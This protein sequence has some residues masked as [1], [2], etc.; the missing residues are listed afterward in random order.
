MLSATSTERFFQR[1]TSRPYA[2]LFLAVLAIAICGT[3]L[4]KLVKDTSVKAFIPAGHESLVADTKAADIFGLSDTIAIA[5][6]TTD[7]SSV[8]R[9]DL[10]ALIAE[11]SDQVAGLPNIRYDRIASL[12]TESSISGEAGWVNIEPY[13][14]PYALDD[15]FAANSRERWE[16]MTP[17]KGTLVSEDGGGAVIMAE[18]IDSNLADATYQAVLDLVSG[19]DTPSVDFHVAGPGAVSAYL[20]RYI[21][22]DARKLQPLVFI[23]VL[24]FIFLAFRRGR[25]LPGPLLVVVG[26]A[27]GSLGIMAWTGTSYF[28]ITNAL[29]VIIVA[30]SVAD[31][32]HILSAYYQLREQDDQAS[33][34]DLVIR[35]MSLMA[36]PVTLTTITTIAGFLGI[37]AM[38][39]MPP[40]TYFGI[41]AS[42]GVLLAWIFSIFVLPNVMLLLDPGRSPA[43][44][45][46]HEGRPSGM[47]RLL[48]KLGTFSPLRYRSVLSAFVLI[49]IAAG[50]GASQLRID[51]SQVENFAADEPIRIADELINERFAGTAFLDVIVETDEP[52]GLLRVDKMSKVRDL[53]L[54]F[55]GLPHVRKTVSIVDYLSQLHGAIEELPEDE[56]N[57]RSLPGSDAELAE[58]LFVYEISGDPTDLEEEIDADYQRALIRG[59]LDAHYFSQNRIAVESLQRYIDEEFNEPGMTA[60]LTGDVNV[61][62][63]WM[64]SLQTSHF[65]GVFLS[66]ALVLVASIVV[67]R[68]LAAGLVSVV[69]VLFTILILYACMGYLGIYLEPAT[70]MFAA[71]ALGVGVDFA[72]HLVDRLRTAT[73][74]YGG[75]LAEAIDKALPPVARA[76]FFNSAALGLGFSVLLVSDLPTLMRFGGLVTLASFSSYLTALIIVPALFAAER[77]WFGQSLRPARSSRVPISLLLIAAVIVGLFGDSAFAATNDADRIA[78]AVAARKEGVAT[79][80]IID[81]TLTDSRGR[82]EERVAVVH[83]QSDEVLRATRITFLEP[84]KRRDMSF[85][86]HD[87]RTSGS[88]DRRWMFLPAARK[89]RSI[90]ASDRGDSFLGTDFS[91]EDMQSELKFNLDDWQFKYGGQSIEDGL[92]RHRLTGTPKNKRIARELGYGAFNALIDEET[93][94]PVTI[95]FVDPKQRPL[96]RIEV[97]SVELI[98]DIW[99]ARNIVATNHQTGHKTE[100]T[101]RN[102]DYLTSLDAVLFEPQTLGRRL[103]NRAKE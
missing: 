18:L 80:R 43:F 73:E 67:F 86:S 88:A 16:R 51:R 35:A 81:M 42:L 64:R 38:S 85:L 89:V 24:G 49:T 71:I 62:Y 84:K 90:P 75:D 96:K 21:D 41:F 6:V 91:F 9:A 47:G 20:G 3:G 30:I 83:K 72:I 31:A 13:I 50:Y 69:P 29:P 102:I 101:F 46:W 5:V 40:I 74:E 27:V 98:D 70:S 32:I 59:V 44:V 76:C 33:V 61:S 37:A 94:M 54:F 10:L 78:Q 82:S 12:A 39:I 19:V 57:A 55:E 63:H 4:T 53:Q 92:V 56:I 68:S 60:S 79:Q 34:R 8:F 97:R 25:A 11:L 66:L 28:A 99:T 26:S 23:V 48:A 36:R 7:G 1:V 100:F 93:W 17:H 95:E 22:Q 52:E 87:Y 58:T 103:S 77:A 65:R 2:V 14:D 45:S 15:S